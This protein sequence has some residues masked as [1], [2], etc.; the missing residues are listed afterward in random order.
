ME[1]Q[2]GSGPVDWSL[3]D[4]IVYI[5]LD[6]RQDRNESIRA[7]LS[8]LNVPQNKVQR[9]AAVESDC[10]F[11]GC[12]KSHLAVLE[13]ARDEK[14]GA[15]LIL[16]DDMAFPHAI[17]DKIRL[18]YIFSQ[19]CRLQWDVTFLAANYFRVQPGAGNS[20]FAP[21]SQQASIMRIRSATCACAYMVRQHYYPTL[22]KNMAQCIA[23]LES[24]GEQLHS[25]DMTWLP[26]MLEDNWLGVYPCLGYQ[27]AS[28]SD[29]QKGYVNYKYLFYKDLEEIMG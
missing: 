12:A 3:V 2:R 8:A 15:V 9:F 4:K 23:R 1:W 25:V 26:L 24:T 27:Q 17:T 28:V 20:D 7:Q 13:M 10:G 18:N 22:I 5:N 21:F 6:R 19:L 29:I 16:E 11:V 14:W